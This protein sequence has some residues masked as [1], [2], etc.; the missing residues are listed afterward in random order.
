MGTGVVPIVISYQIMIK[1]CLKRLSV[2]NGIFLLSVLLAGCSAQPRHVNV[3]KARGQQVELSW[4]LPPAEP[5]IKFLQDIKGPEDIKVKESF[6][7]KLAGFLFGKEE[8][9]IVK[10]YGIT[11]DSLGRIIITDI[12]IKKLHVFDMKKKKYFQIPK[13]VD[14]ILKSPIGVAVD[15]LD[16]I[17]VS[18]SVRKK[19]FVF[20]KGGRKIGEIEGE[21]G[22][23]TGLAIN[24]ENE[25]LYVV[26]TTEHR[27]KVFN[28]KGDLKGVIGERG[29]NDG[30]FN[31][32]TNIFIDN[33]GLIYITDS[34]NFRVQIFNSEGKFVS[35]FGK[36]GNG[37]GDF[38]RPKGISVDSEGHI[39]IIEGLFDVVQ[40]F[41]RKGRFLLPFGQTGTDL[42]EF[43]LPTG[44]FIDEEDRIYVADSYNSRIQVF[45][46]LT[47]T[48]QLTTD[49]ET[50]Y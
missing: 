41:D 49:N 8:N 17:Y 35:R 22:R 27:V 18:D 5:R 50:K 44:L 28:L 25:I 1:N 30:E 9:S 7:E 16:N 47:E 15:A 33:E 29:V 24:K 21:F 38:S 31:Y 13:S 39:Y 37:S 10:P 36:H 6:F 46:Y 4:P 32:P 42:G 20:N 34:M 11:V 19:V 3:E 26:D 14:N 12:G 40:I 23:P 45:Q 48:D 2:I 43:W